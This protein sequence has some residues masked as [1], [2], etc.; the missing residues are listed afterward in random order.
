MSRLQI[1][2]PIEA[3]IVVFIFLP[4][5]IAAGILG[6]GED[7]QY[8][9]EIL[10]KRKS[11]YIYCLFWFFMF[12]F[13]I[14]CMLYLPPAF[15]SDPN[16]A[17][18]LWDFKYVHVLTE[19]VI[20]TTTLLSIGSA[21]AL[22]RF[23]AEHYRILLVSILYTILVVSRSYMLELIFYWGLASFL[24]SWNLSLKI[25]I[26]FRHVCY[27]F[28]IFF[29]FIVYGNWRQGSSFSIV[30]YGEMSVDSNFLAWIFGYFLVNFHNLA[31]LIV[32]N[33]QNG[34]ISNVLGSLIQ[35]LQLGVFEFVN[36]YP[37]VG[38]FNLGTAIRPFILDFGPWLGGLV[39]ALTWVVMVAMPSLCKTRQ[40]QYALIAL[41]AYTAF[42]LPITSRI[43][44]PP[45]LFP[46]I[47]IVLN[48]RFT[49]LG[50]RL[51]KQKP[52]QPS[53]GA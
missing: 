24:I 20:R 34:S 18:M 49:L 6:I 29:I 41:I 7:K 36:D 26:K 39:F 10:L 21:I 14:Q 8:K 38:K 42:C 50:P 33:F 51:I 48:D 25:P 40:T 5:C 53:V 30:E 27:S 15:A 16:E 52:I 22:G 3:H 9:P 19:I 12:I 2:W 47:W 46:L 35:T 28:L 1:D 37:Y 17:R 44:Q 43:E 23:R 31:L 11:R 45:Y 32:K 13:M 4:L